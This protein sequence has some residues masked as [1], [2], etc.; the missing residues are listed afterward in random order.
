MHHEHAPAGETLLE[1]RGLAKTFGGL[2]AVNDFSFEVKKGSVTALIGP[3]GAGKTTAFNMVTGVIPPTAG[4][5]RL[6]GTELAGLRADQICRL[7]VAR[8]F[9]NIR[10]FE[11]QTV[12]SNVMVGLHRRLEGGLLAALLR[13]PRARQEEAEARAAA[14]RYLDFVGLLPRVN[15]CAASLAY[16][17]RRRLEIARAL[18]SGP[19]LL[20]L[21]EPAAGM[22]PQ[23][24]VE[25]MALIL[26]I[27]DAGI[28]VLLIEH[29]MKLVMEIS[30]TIFV[31]DHGEEIARGA[32]ADVRSDPK[33]IHAYLGVP[34]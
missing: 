28:T 20:L 19:R 25:L 34:D 3:N 23:E 4:S 5:I 24:T 30:D 9:Q 29:D 6:E 31:L 18:A 16:G 13:T 17:E 33:V 15:D 27:R 26:R 1:V 14:A 22:N 8:T 10:L 32:P 2:R 21:D 7:G 12:L 11:D